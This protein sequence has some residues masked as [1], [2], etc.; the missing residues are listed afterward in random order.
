MSEYTPD[1]KVLR[2]VLCTTD[3]TARSEPALHRAVALA[4]QSGA[5]LTIVHATANRPPGRVMRM[6]INRAYVQLLS[7]LDKLF[8]SQAKL[9]DV[10]VRAGSAPQLIVDTANEVDADLVVM[11]PPRPRRFDWIVGTTAE[12]FIRATNRPLLVVHRPV[13]GNYRNVALATDLSNA[14]VPML[15]TAAGLG[16]LDHA[17]ATIVHALRDPY[18]NMLRAAGIDED[19]IDR[20][21]VSYQQEIAQRLESMIV[22]AGLAVER[23]RVR[24]RTDPPALAIREVLE[25]EQPELLAIGASRWFLMKRVFIGSVADELL[26]APMCDM[27]VIPHQSDWTKITPRKRRGQA[28]PTTHWSSAAA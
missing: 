17:Q 25:R 3:L 15:R 6:Q 16:V 28:V 22:H 4:R 19:M 20:S 8:N 2:R 23:T 26:R 21:Y 10:V 1:L 18:E 12:R 13:E 9:V 27:L 14:S 7:K 11:A 24:V 5:R